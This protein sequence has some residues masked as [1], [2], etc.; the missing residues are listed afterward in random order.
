MVLH[1]QTGTALESSIGAARALAAA[2]TAAALLL[3]ACAKQGEGERCDLNN[4]GLDCDTGLICIS[5]DQLSLEDRRGVAVCCPA[6][7]ALATVDACRA[8][9]ELV[10]EPPL[11]DA[12]QTPPAP[13]AAD[14]GDGG[15]SSGEL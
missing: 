5:A 11:V 14:A 8:G 6:G 15:A 4:G 10:E 7:N 3:S 12:G 1:R 13:P 9:S 2:C